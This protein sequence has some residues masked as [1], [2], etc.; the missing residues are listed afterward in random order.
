M[1][2]YLIIQS[3]FPATVLRCIV[4]YPSSERR[5]RVKIV[6]IIRLLKDGMIIHEPNKQ[7]DLIIIG[8]VPPSSFHKT[9]ASL[10]YLESPRSI[11]NIVGWTERTAI[12]AMPWCWGFL[13]QIKSFTVL[14]LLQERLLKLNYRV[15]SPPFF[16]NHG[17]YWRASAPDASVNV[18]NADVVKEY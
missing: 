12:Q 15:P 17:W 18:V 1:C 9:I 11:R 3:I 14:R 13:I 7:L 16:W 6:G 2:V 10:G 8:V 5:V 4:S